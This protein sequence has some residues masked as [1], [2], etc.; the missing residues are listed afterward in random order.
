ME[1]KLKQ[2]EAHFA[3]GKIEE[4]EK[5]FLEILNENPKNKEAYNN[6]GVI[7]FQRQDFEQALEY[8]TKVLE[9]DPFHKDAILNYS[10]LLKSTNRFYDST[11]ILEKAIER[12]PDDQEISRLLSEVRQM[13]RSGTKIAVLCLPGLQSF[14]GDIVGYL[15]TKYDV[16]TCYS[17]NNQE[18]ESAVKWAD[19]VWLEWANELTIALT[20]HPTILDSKHIICRLHSY[21]AF[22]GYAGKIN[23]GKISDLIFVAEH[24]KNIVLQQ[25]PDL[26]NKVKNI[27]IVP[28]GVNL[29]KFPFK[30]RSKGTNLAY[31]GHIN[32][33]KGPM[34]LLHAFRELVQAD[35]RYRLF[36][37]GDFQDARYELYFNQMIKEMNLAN[38]IQMDGWV[39][40]VPDWLE[41]KQYI[42]CTSVLEGHPVGLMEAMACGLKPVIHN[43]VG[44]RGLYP[45]KFIWNTIPE[46][47]TMVTN[48][49]YDP[50]EYR[51]FIEDKFS[52]QQLTSIEAIV[53]NLV[54]QSKQKIL[55]SSVSA[56]EKEIKKGEKL[57]AGG[58][59]E[60]AER[61]FGHVL[62]QDPEN[63]EAYN[64]LGVIAYERGELESAGH[65]FTE[66]LRIAPFYREGIINLSMVFESQGRHQEMVPVLKKYM[67]K[68]PG[69]KELEALFGRAVSMAAEGYA[70]RVSDNLKKN[71]SK[72]NDRNEKETYPVDEASDSLSRSIRWIKANVIPDKGII[73]SSG[74][75]MSYPEVTGYFIPTLYKI[76]EKDLAKQFACWLT[77]VQLSDG[78][79]PGPS[80]RRSYAFD[81]G[82][83]VRG[84]VAA[85]PDMP[86]LEEPLRRACDWLV[87][88]SESSGRLPVPSASTWSLG[89]RGSIPE[90]L[91]IYVLPSLREAGR[92]L[93][94]K[95]YL[96]FVER[97]LSYYKKNADLTN[98][99]RS[100]ALTYFFAY[101]QEALFD[102]GEE[103]LAREG[104]ENVSRYQM[105]N[106]AVPAYFDV[107]WVCSTGLAQLALVWYKLG[108]IRRA[109]SAMNFLEILQNSSGGFWGSYG[110]GANYFVSEEISW[111]VK[112]YID[113]YQYR[114]AGYFDATADCY[115]VKIDESDGRFQS[116]LGNCGDCNN[117]RILDVGCGNGRYASML[118]RRYP[119]AGIIGLDISQE[120]LNAAPKGIRTVQDSILNMPFENDTFDVV[121]CIE[122]LEHAVN[123]EKAISEGIRVLAPGGT[124][125]IIDKNREKLGIR[126]IPS[127]EKWFDRDEILNMIREKGVNASAEFISY[128]NVKK[129][130]G[131]FIGWSG[132]KEN[133]HEGRISF[134]KNLD[135]E[136]WHES[137]IGDGK[138]D[139]I[140]G[141]IRREA[142]PEWIA[143]VIE[144]TKAGDR[145]LE[146]GSGTGELSAFLA[147]KGRNV[148]LLDFSQDN[149]DF[150]RQVFELLNL[151]AD[152]V[153]ADVTKKLPFDDDSFDF[154]WSSGL[155]EH[156]EDSVISH[157]IEES[158]RVT[159]SKVFSLVPNASSLAYRLGKW[160]QECSGSWKWGKEDP[161]ITM[162]DCF[163]RAG[164]QNVEEYSVATRHS[165]NFLKGP[166]M[167]ALAGS[168]KAFYDSLSPQE[169]R[170]INQGYLLATIGFKGT[171]N[172]SDL[173]NNIS[174]TS[175]EKSNTRQQHSKSNG[176]VLK[177]RRQREET[178][179]VGN[180][181]TQ[182]R[183]AD[184]FN[185]QF[186]DVSVALASAPSETTQI[187]WEMAQQGERRF[188]ENWFR[189][190][191]DPTDSRWLNRVLQSFGLEENQHFEEEV[192]VDIGAGPLGILTK[193]KAKRK[194]AVDPL[195]F[196]TTDR[197]IER[198]KAPGEKIPL[199]NDVAGRIFIYNVLQ[200]VCSPV[201]ILDEIHR[202]LKPGGTVYLWEQLNLPANQTHPHSLKLELFEEWLERHHLDVIERIHEH[203]CYFGEPKYAPGTGYSTLCLIARKNNARERVITG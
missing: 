53:G 183:A 37:A 118:L 19:I 106:G 24:I 23:W 51:G 98:F 81:T 88:S 5:C 33:K 15:R 41:D 100:N 82:Q 84:W 185:K 63:K 181:H 36:I 153:M 32:Y 61:V 89:D 169:L 83:V 22:A 184:Y 172:E 69:D 150:S 87:G 77:T 191:D 138:V 199:D 158:K 40:D 147:S 136:S 43:F 86:E 109:D 114:I 48:S 187:R 26:L 168:L 161:L 141:R 160:Q 176:K 152:Y 201:K 10:A 196:D 6:L 135:A 97:S 44:A 154:V 124:L 127:W 1:E 45:D 102:L 75:R 95:P 57:F 76:G 20:N 99:E 173:V 188:W 123:I 78:S 129:P 39:D 155:L 34:L 72:S 195:A 62:E 25:V 9:I 64:N 16:R 156:F 56:V 65:F 177:Q 117:K 11:P 170:T 132:R 126:E 144:N 66:S 110:I 162:I 113:A 38:N 145:L 27:H 46:F 107:S 67:E 60:K 140:V 96:E 143:S 70:S 50:A 182:S 4:A 190:T 112:Y 68:F 94:E 200:H 159:N 85:F 13:R 137:L 58:E 157:I 203:D 59:L 148:V 125:I 179:S 197:S 52:L 103:G 108:E 35:N 122:A 139:E 71:T 186:N 151:E 74:K 121:Y 130:D 92:L 42:V 28:N 167:S 198:I 18:I 93:G 31:V 79:I 131:W 128:G 17:N 165:L 192:I 101:V 12:F 180:S 133:A 104:M 163:E 7:S 55:S 2:G 194:I 29:D 174:E 90:G 202:L 105:D 3:E 47:V 30:D 73:V 146:L 8:F 111:A 166:E 54:K 189:S 91:H 120:L 171:L 115:D 119:Q 193:L 149:L 134:Q 164:L 116:L 49:D 175:K 178:A 21:E 80:D 14:L 142:V